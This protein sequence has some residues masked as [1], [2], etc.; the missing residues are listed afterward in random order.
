M[1]SKKRWIVIASLAVL[2]TV[3]GIVWLTRSPGTPHQ[4]AARQEKIAGVGAVN[5]PPTGTTP[6]RQPETLPAIAAEGVV[7][8]T[9]QNSFG[10]ELTQADQQALK[11][12][13]VEA[14]ANQADL[15]RALAGRL[16][17]REGA[18]EPEVLWAAIR[19]ESDGR[20][21]RV[22][23]DAEGEKWFTVGEDGYPTR[24]EEVREIEQLRAKVPGAKVVGRWGRI[25]WNDLLQ[26]EA[27][28]GR[29]T[30]VTWTALSQRKVLHCDERCICQ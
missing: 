12:C 28:D 24:V 6:A 21:F 30:E 16:R 14:V 2:A 7:Q 26:V 17:Q 15:A 11:E 25:I 22:R 13:A 5:V 3:I 23:R 10:R 27:K 9:L 4:D 20:E 19:Y 29:V 18:T 8:H 1:T